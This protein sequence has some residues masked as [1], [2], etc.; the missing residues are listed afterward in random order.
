MHSD[1]DIDFAEPNTLAG[2]DFTLGR[3]E[4]ANSVEGQLL[5]RAPRV[6]VVAGG[7][8]FDVGSNE[9]TTTAIVDFLTQTTAADTKIKH[10]N[11]YAYA[12]FALPAGLTLTAGASGDLFD[13]T[14]NSYAQGTTFAGLPS[15]GLEPVA[16]APVLGEK[17]QFNPKVGAT[18]AFKSGTTL[19][20]AWF[21]TLKRTLVT[22]QTL[23]P[24]Q[25]A[26]FNQFFDDATATKSDVWGLALDQKLGKRAFVGA[27]YMQRDMT[28]PQT[29]FD[30]GPPT[31]VSIEERTGKENLARG[32]LLGAPHRLLTLGAEYSYEKFERDPSLFLPYQTLKTRRVPLTARFFHPSGISAFAAATW[33]KQE[34]DFLTFDETG[35]PSYYAGDQS[36]WVVDAGLRYRLPKR[37]GF[38][39]AGVNNLTDEKSTYQ[40]TDAKNLA[41]QPGRVIYGR[42]VVAFP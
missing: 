23:E 30:L 10:T 20:G 42:V 11:L 22:D 29:L 17:N 4:K 7:G 25:V 39:V 2:V 6:R 3:K 26:G 37:Y 24:T 13:E 16:P 40:S 8:Y 9:T 12:H 35:Q 15:G 36:F 41:Y 1:K 14:A 27:D 34:G 21:R 32:Y 33:I 19:R 31:V 5:Y 18:W 38:L 28:I